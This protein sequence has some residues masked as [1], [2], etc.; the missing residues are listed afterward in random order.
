MDSQGLEVQ[1]TL[2]IMSRAQ[3][4]GEVTKSSLNILLLCYQ[5]GPIDR[6][7]ANM[8]P[9]STLVRMQLEKLGVGIP[10]MEPTHTGSLSVF[11]K[12]FLVYYS[13]P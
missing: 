7:H 11:G 6:K 12:Y 8:I 9:P 3:D 4:T 10:L 2:P 13:N 5:G 1:P